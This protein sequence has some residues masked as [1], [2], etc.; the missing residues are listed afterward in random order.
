MSSDATS[1]AS[2]KDEVKKIDQDLKGELLKGLPLKATEVTEKN[3][4]PTAQDVA[5]EKTHLGKS[6]RGKQDAISRLHILPA[7]IM[8][9]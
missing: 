4:L 1:M 9:L 6:T 2:L 7:L 5:Q 8:N 3:V